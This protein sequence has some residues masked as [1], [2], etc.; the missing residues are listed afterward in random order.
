M[1][2]NINEAKDF[3]QKVLQAGLVP[4]LMGSPGLGKSDV[5]RQVADDNNLAVIDVRLSQSD[6][7]DMNGFPSLN[8]D[9]T[10]SHYAPPDTF[11]IEGDPLPEGK[12]GWLLFFD[13]MNAAPLS[14]QAAAYKIVLDRQVGN[15]NLH[16]KVAMVCAGNLTTDKAIVSRL[17]TAMQSRLIHFNLQISN[18]A[19]IDWAGANDIDH[20]IIGYINFRPGNLHKFDPNHNDN[21]FPCPRTWAFLSRIIKDMPVLT[22]KDLPIMAG[23]IGEGPAIEFRGFTEIYESLP[24]IQQMITSPETVNISKEPS[25]Q[26]AISSLIG[27]KATETTIEPLL[28][29]IERLPVEFQVIT[30]QGIFKKDKDKKIRATAC[31]RA[32][33]AANASA[34]M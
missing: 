8:E 28:K 12:D 19:W 13:E 3:I 23:T 7:T 33:I 27:A 18:K 1:Q 30:V 14:V 29:V 32:W 6:P 22:V 17:S 11:P 34:L 2:I 20:R 25:I 21:T 24:T 15:H 26:Y 9:R 31:L 10:R 4:N 5:I 16:E